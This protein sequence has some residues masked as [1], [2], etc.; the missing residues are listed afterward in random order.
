[1]AAPDPHCPTEAAPVACDEADRL[2]APLRGLRRVGIAVSGGADSLAL[3]VLLAEWRTNR[4][5]APDLIVFTIDHGLRADS[6]AETRHV[7]Q[8]AA[9]FGLPC[10]RLRWEGEKPWTNL[11][12]AARAARQALLCDALRAEGGAAL[13]LAHHLDDQA[14]TFLLRLARGSGVQGLG[15]MREA[16]RWGDMPVLRPLLGV[17]KAGLVATLRARGIDWC[18]DPSNADR[19]H[20]RVR[21]RDLMPALGSEGLTARRLSETAGRLARA[22]RALDDRVARLLRDHARMHPAGPV[23]VSVAALAEVP[24]EILLRTLACLL[25]RVGGAAYPPRMARL[26]RLVETLSGGERVQATLAGAVVRRADGVLTLWRETGRAGIAALTVTGPGVWIW[27][28]RFVLRAD[29]P[30]A[31]D[32][33][34]RG[35]PQAAAPEVPAEIRAAGWPG[36]AFATAPCLRSG[37][38]GDASYCPGLGGEGPPDGV[39]LTPLERFQP[40]VAPPNSLARRGNNEI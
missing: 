26:E 18:E 21:L 33:R 7:A 34:A 2:F 39:A 8:L 35:D 36:E 23:R 27:D 14:E 4:P 5:D 28:G 22:G 25:Q 3:M 6:D 17:P 1:V 20:A 19:A 9:R 11:Q 29:T 40:V 10:R 32:L 38:E 12:A 37:G 13:V 31:L 15:A 16:D 30:V 24:E